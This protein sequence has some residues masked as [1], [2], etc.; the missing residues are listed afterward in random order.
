MRSPTKFHFLLL[1]TTALHLAPAPSLAFELNTDR[2]GG[3]FTSSEV[4]GNDPRVNDLQ[5]PTHW[6]HSEIHKAVIPCF[7]LS[8]IDAYVEPYHEICSGFLARAALQTIAEEQK[9][10]SAVLLTAT[11]TK[12]TLVFKALTILMQKH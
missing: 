10:A 6:C 8:K 9:A 11:Q 1:F 2:P 7:V 12:P 5:H 4:P 3:D